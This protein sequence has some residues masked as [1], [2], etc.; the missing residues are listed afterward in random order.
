MRS[1][2]STAAVRHASRAFFPGRRLP[3]I[4]TRRFDPHLVLPTAVAVLFAGGLG[5]SVWGVWLRPRVEG[6]A[7][8]SCPRGVV[9]SA[10]P[11]PAFYENEAA[12]RLTSGCDCHPGELCRVRC[13]AT[14]SCAGSRP[15]IPG[16]A[17]TRTWDTGPRITCGRSASGVPLPTTAS[18]SGRPRW[19]SSWK[20]DPGRWRGGSHEGK[21]VSVLPA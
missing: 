9:L 7:R 13:S 17:G 18:P 15:G 4:G 19:S 10:I 8:A 14:A 5:L 3:L 1:A 20:A 2:A 11:V 16:T 21:S 12:A 6:A